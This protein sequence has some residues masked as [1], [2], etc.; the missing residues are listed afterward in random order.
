MDGNRGVSTNGKRMTI[1]GVDNETNKFSFNYSTPINTWH[2]MI[3]VWLPNKGAQ[4]IYVINSASSS[5]YF[6]CNG[7]FIT[8]GAITL[9][10]PVKNGLKGSIAAFESYSDHEDKRVPTKIWKL[11]FN[12]QLL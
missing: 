6:S 9:G 11:I 10:G 1:Y 3:V 4:G 12:A 2:T 8:S 7:N 5:D